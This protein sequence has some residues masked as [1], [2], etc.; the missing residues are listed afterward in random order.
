MPTPL[1][2][3]TE[4]GGDARDNALLR[5]S[6]W[7]AA[8]KECYICEKSF[9]KL[10][11]VD[12]D[13]ILPQHLKPAEFNRLWTA[14]AGNLPN[15]G[16]DH[17]SNLR[18]ACKLCNSNRRKGA[19]VLPDTIIAIHLGHSAGITTKALTEQRKMRRNSAMGESL[20]HL[21][22]ASK[23]DDFKVLW[24]PDLNQALL[25]SLYEASRVLKGD[26]V[27]RSM[28]KSGRF[29]DLTADALKT[30]MLAALHL[31]SGVTSDLLLDGFAEYAVDLIQQKFASVVG[32]TYEALR[33]PDIG[34]IDWGQ[35]LFAISIDDV[36]L[37]SDDWSCAV[38]VSVETMVSAPV[39]MQSEDG[40]EL[41][42]GQSS[43]W[44]VAAEI[45]LKALVGM[46]GFEVESEGDAIEV[47]LV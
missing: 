16:I 1:P 29:V 18:A 26:P 37:A 45:N 15:Q 47:T 5:Y 10:H 19:I 12:I 36:T 6:L 32:A 28:W 23:R 9:K 21:S 3:V 20:V 39:T 30:R 13:H 43:E 7:Q 14:L 25:D 46:R 2:V 38:T 24:D 42:D 27:R 41:V 35:T 31:V 8:G 34:E 4:Y 22:T 33:G 17:I 11:E 44:E 40:S